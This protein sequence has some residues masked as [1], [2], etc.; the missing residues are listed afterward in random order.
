MHKLRGFRAPGTLCPT[1]ARKLPFTNTYVGFH[2]CRQRN[3]EVDHQ[4]PP[5]HPAI[6]HLVWTLIYLEAPNS[7]LTD[8]RITPK[9]FFGRSPM[10]RPTAMFFRPPRPT[11]PAR[12]WKKHSVTKTAARYPTPVGRLLRHQPKLPSVSTCANSKSINQAK[13]ISAPIIQKSGTTPSLSLR[14]LDHWLDYALDIGRWN[15]SSVQS[16]LGK[17]HL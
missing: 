13:S 8:P 4:L 16:L 2:N 7:Q 14:S 5:F 9:K 15:M 3:L 11:Y 10:P 1:Q 17:E 12:R 6:Q